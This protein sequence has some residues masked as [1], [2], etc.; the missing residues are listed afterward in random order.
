MI[1]VEQCAR[2]DA[3]NDDS[4]SNNQNSLLSDPQKYAEFK[5]SIFKDIL[6]PAKRKNDGDDGESKKL[7]ID[8]GE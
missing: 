5:N 8:K 1:L 4:N 7:K 2:D 3:A 6:G